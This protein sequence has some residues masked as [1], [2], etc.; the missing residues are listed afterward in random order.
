[1]EV[2]EDDYRRPG[3]AAIATMKTIYCTGYTDWT[4]ARE[5]A[6]REVRYHRQEGLG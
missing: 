2:V 1:M 3:A 5:N 6:G 4:L